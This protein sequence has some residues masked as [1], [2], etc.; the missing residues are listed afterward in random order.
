MSILLTGG[1]GF[2][3]SHTAIE[4]LKEGHDV[5]IIDNLSNSTDDIITKISTITKKSITFYN[6]DINNFDDLDLIFTNHQINTV[7]H[8][9]AFKAVGESVSNP[10]KYYQN[11]VG[12]LLSLLK[13]MDKH[14]VTNIIFSSSATV[15]GDPEILPI[16]ENSLLSAINPY[17]QTKLIG[18]NILRDLYRSNDKYK[19]IILRYFNPVGAHESG[20]IGESP[21]GRPNNLFPYILDV[22]KGKRAHL[23]I[24]GNDYNTPDGTGIRDYIHV[25][26]LAQGHVKSLDYIVSST[27]NFINTYNLGTGKG[28]SVLDIVTEFSYHT[29]I[30]YKMVDRRKGDS[31]QVYADCS[32][33][34]NELGWVSTKTLKDMVKDSLRFIGL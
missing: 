8:F 29:T 17:G 7:I 27:A 18:E 20:L 22:A 3:G 11:N 16:T 4:L 1:T 10:L 13:T 26:D 30:K 28:Y 14:D 6:A 5:I 12:G 23:N 15:Y 33:A 32:L 21:L 9:A 19:I 24:Y 34:K 31:P 25:V 2:I